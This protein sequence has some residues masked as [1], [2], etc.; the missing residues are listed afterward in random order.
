MTAHFVVDRHHE[1]QPDSLTSTLSTSMSSPPHSNHS[2]IPFSRHTSSSTSSTSSSCSSES[3]VTWADAESSTDPT[4]VVYRYHQQRKQQQTDFVTTT[5]MPP[6][7]ETT[8]AINIS[9]DDNDN[10]GGDVDQRNTT[11]SV[12]PLRSYGKWCPAKQGAT[13]VWRDVC[14]YATRTP[15]EAQSLRRT[16][17]TLNASTS[18]AAFDGGLNRS[19]QSANAGRSGDNGG[20]LKRIINN[21]TGAIQAGTLMALMGSR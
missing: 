16:Q 14:V 12:F 8:N 6:T 1:Q 20:Q 7:T 17:R 11:A 13:L 19:R 2:R 21:A 3:G 9:D 4:A 5:T 15:A 18:G 10:D